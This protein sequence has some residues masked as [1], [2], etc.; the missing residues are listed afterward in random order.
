[1]FSELPNLIELEKENKVD[2]L[3]YIAENSLMAF[4][5]IYLRHYFK[6]SIAEFQREIYGDL[7]NNDV[8][9]LEVI[10]FRGSAKST[11]S[12]LAFPLWC[13]IFKKRN[14]II[15]ASDTFTQAKLIIANL[16]YEL[17]G[18]EKI[19]T[20]FGGFK[21][22]EEWT[23]TNIFLKNGVRIMSRSR[24]QKIRG[25]R[26]LQYRPDLVVADDVENIED[27][28]TKEQRD[29]TYEWFYSDVIPAMDVTIGK[30]VLIGNMLHS[31]SLM[32]RVKTKIQEQHNGVLKE[33]PLL[34]ENSLSIWED[35][36]TPDK[37]AELKKDRF[38]QR[39]YLLKPMVGEGQLVKK[40][41][42][43]SS[44]PKD[45]LRRIA[46][47]VDLAISKKDEAD[48]S[49][50][51][52]LAQD[53]NKKMYNL[54]NIYGRWNFNETLSNIYT[55]YQT[56]TK[57]YPHLAV[58]LGFEDVAY[59]RAAIEEFYR[60]YSI[61]PIS[62][63]QTKDKRARIETTL[64]YIENEQVLFGREGM[65]DLEIQLLNFGTE[66]YD[67]CVDAFEISMR[68]LLEHSI[69]MIRSL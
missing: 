2:Q 14:F 32:S 58:L 16:I 56:Y 18:N 49:A 31:D 69:P 3:K 13:A 44:V 52:V 30:M 59:Q 10:A 63:K 42:Y 26:H 50:I 61:Q 62:I 17:E 33:Y 54:K 1:M 46:I 55:V 22:K 40:L 34:D 43:Y 65:E 25:L 23:A 15:L 4:A 45:T 39:E 19:R 8:R 51:N 47:G 28:R 57:V 21:G 48:Y 6:A 12:A 53:G 66:R 35:F 36:Y 24:G 5:F 41:F 37:I 7:Q 67:D 29:K 11:I 20:H 9:F 64:P 27:I 68:I 38:W 60:R